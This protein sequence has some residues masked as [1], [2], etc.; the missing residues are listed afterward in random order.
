M[1]GSQK[2]LKYREGKGFALFLKA[3]STFFNKLS[4]S[5]LFASHQELC[6]TPLS[7]HLEETDTA[8]LNSGEKPNSSRLTDYSQES[9]A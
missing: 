5:Y 4:D 6:N 3:K 2:I 7:H 1:D 9:F 8:L